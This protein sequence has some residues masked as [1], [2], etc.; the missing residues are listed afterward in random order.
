LLRRRTSFL[1]A[2][3]QAALLF[4]GIGSSAPT[5]SLPLPVSDDELKAARTHAR[6]AKGADAYAA[7][8]SAGRAALSRLPADGSTPKS[9]K[10]AESLLKEAVKNLTPT[11]HASLAALL[12]RP[13]ISEGFVKALIARGN[14]DEARAECVDGLARWGPRLAPA[15]VEAWKDLG[16]APPDVRHARPSP[17]Q[18]WSGW[19]MCAQ[20]GGAT[21]SIYRV[22]Y[23]H[24]ASDSTEAVSPIA[25]RSAFDLGLEHALGPRVGE[26]EADVLESDGGLLAALETAGILNAKGA[27]AFVIGMDEPVLSGSL[28]G[29]CALGVPVFATHWH[30]EPVPGTSRDTAEA[31]LVFMLTPSPTTRA[32]ALLAHASARQAK[33]IVIAMPEVGGDQALAAALESQARG[34]PIE[35]FVYATG[36]RDY[37]PEVRELRTRDADALVLLGPAE[38][39]GEWL[40]ALDKARLRPFIYGTEELDPAGFH[41]RVRASAEDVVYVGSNF[42]LTDSL[43]ALLRR[44]SGEANA[45]PAERRFYLAGRA[46]GEAIAGGAYSP[47][48]LR[49]ALSRRPG[50]TFALAGRS[51]WI[52]WPER[53]ASIPIY[54]VRGGTAARIH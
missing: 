22:G 25:L 7:W 34:L 51:A 18:G 41:E 35:R 11:G 6:K 19:S 53:I 4:A 21:R 46:L 3:T 52:E 10:E 36:R 37:A 26:F 24:P 32:R 9:E 50:T 40:L 44:A 48:T 47:G 29:A 43:G 42:V 39:S 13:E 45:D 28:A 8:H 16:I 30:E 15:L 14:P 33:R 5:L 54:R 49:Q 31:P 12:R 2:A 20:A 38:E 23:L 1:L 17:T 27:G